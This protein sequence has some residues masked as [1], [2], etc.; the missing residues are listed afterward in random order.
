M[1][2]LGIQ[3]AKK[4]ARRFMFRLVSVAHDI[5]KSLLITGVK[6]EPQLAIPIGTMGFVFAGKHKERKVALKVV[7]RGRNDVSALS[8]SLSPHAY[9]LLRIRSEES[10]A[11]KS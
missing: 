9:C 8:F 7:G 6:I 1:K 10:S 11:G 2:N 5:P 4:E 3:D